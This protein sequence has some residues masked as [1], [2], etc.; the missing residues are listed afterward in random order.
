M[1]C[2]S[3]AQKRLPEI[4]HHKF[5]QKRQSRVGHICMAG[6]LRALCSA[7]KSTQCRTGAVG[8]S[9]VLFSQREQWQKDHTTQLGAQGAAAGN[10]QPQ[11]EADGRH[12]W[13]LWGCF[14]PC[15]AVM[16]RAAEWFLNACEP[17]ERGQLP[18]PSRAKGCPARRHRADG[19]PPSRTTGL[20]RSSS[21]RRPR[22]GRDAAP[23]A[24]GAGRGLGANRRGPPPPPEL[25]PRRAPGSGP[26]P[27][28]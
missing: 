17:T 20:R 13:P 2:C 8:G 4:K 19:G 7:Q 16:K 6:H 21:A 27:G 15:S 12:L 11:A 1:L 3:F 9:A 28:Q 25:C 5:G 26:G 23:R 18:L 10:P 24:G 22:A 14:W